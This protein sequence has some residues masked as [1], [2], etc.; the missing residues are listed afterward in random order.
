MFKLIN[1][2]DSFYQWDLNQK[3]IVEDSSVD[4]VHFCNKTDD[5]SLVCEV[6]EQDGKRLVNVPNI[7]L[8]EAWDIRAYAYC[9]DC[10][11]K[12]SERFKVIARTKPADY[13]YTE[14]EIK[15]WES[16]EARVEALE[17]SGGGSGG[18]SAIKDG[19]LLL[20]GGLEIRT[21][22]PYADNAPTTNYIEIGKNIDEDALLTI[23]GWDTNSTFGHDRV[24]L[25][26]GISRLSVTKFNG[27]EL[28][29]ESGVKIEAPTVNLIGDDIQI[30]RSGT[31]SPSSVI[32]KAELDDTKRELENT[33]ASMG[34]GGGAWEQIANVTTTE[35]VN[36]VVCASYDSFPAMGNIQDFYMLITLP[37][38]N[39][40]VEGD[41]RI[42]INNNCV[43]RIQDFDSGYSYK[44]NAQFYSINIPNTS[45]MNM[46]QLKFSANGF[47]SL[48]LTTTSTV[49]S[50]P[51][52]SI[53]ITLATASSVLPIGTKIKIVGWVEQ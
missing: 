48:N 33:I 34:S 38:H 36:T 44:C 26:S 35:E 1:D 37:I 40:K 49:V 7:L 24:D 15:S 31:L 39:T 43:A 3:L 30:S 23:K 46:C 8:T 4:E 6:Y 11:T 53:S 21:T 47:S 52:E 28:I 9:N 16:I 51:I 19:E 45:R 22:N 42:Y 32:T 17:A 25:T 41:M 12:Q 5:C 18:G 2:R 10:Y 29:G 50:E 14:T 27:T 13:V 20:D